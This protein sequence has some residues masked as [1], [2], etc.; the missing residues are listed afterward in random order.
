MIRDFFEKKTIGGFYVPA[1]S[2][3]LSIVAVIVFPV[4]F[5]GSNYVTTPVIVLPLA[6]SLAY[7]VLSLSEKTDGFASLV[8]GVLQFAAL[9][10]F[11]SDTYLYLSE[12]FY[13]GFNMAA[14][15]AMNLAWPA[16]LFLL[17]ANVVLCNIGIYK[18]QDK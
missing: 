1:L 9:L 7:I 18:K 8:A 5:S 16:T 3:L 11:I 14:I 10:C 13:G 17:L 12:A 4:G 6:A 2:I 15:A